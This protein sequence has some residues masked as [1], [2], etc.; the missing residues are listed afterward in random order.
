[1]PACWS[2]SSLQQNSE[3]APSACGDG[4]RMGY[5]ENN[6]AVSGGGDRCQWRGRYGSVEGV[7]VVSRGG[8]SSQ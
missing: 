8:V 1:M 7:L 3:T 5:H 2:N 4:D 6:G